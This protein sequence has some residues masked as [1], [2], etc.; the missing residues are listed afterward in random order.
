MLLIH[1]DE[2]WCLC[3]TDQRERSSPWLEAASSW[4]LY[5]DARLNSDVR[6]H[7]S[8]VDNKLSR[9]HYHRHQENVNRLH[10]NTPVTWQKLIKFNEMRSEKVSWGTSNNHLISCVVFHCL[11]SVQER[12]CPKKCSTFLSF[13][14]SWSIFKNSFIAGKSVKFSTI[15]YVTLSTTPEICCRT[16]RKLNV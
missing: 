6:R 14:K 9:Y 8:P 3:G 7:L 1:R 5:L 13:V 10:K 2:R 11:R 16:Q 15:Q 12:L 4:S